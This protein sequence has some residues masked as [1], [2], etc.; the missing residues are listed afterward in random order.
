MKYQTIEEVAAKWGVT[1]RQV[2]DYCTKGRISGVTFDGKAWRIPSNATKPG[3]KPRSRPQSPSILSILREE[4]EARMPG[5]IYHRLQIDFTYSSNHMEGSRLTHE[6]T[7]WI[8]ETHTVGEIGADVPVDDIVETANH[9]RAIDSVITSARAALTERYIKNL[10]AILKGGTTDSRKPW[11]AVGN[12]KRLENSVGGIETAPPSRV[13]ADM[14]RLLAWYNA[15]GH[16]FEDILAFHVRFETIHPFQD[17]NGRIGRLILLKEC[18]KHGITPFI[19]DEPLR[20]F[21][22]RGLE[23]WRKDIRGYLLDTCRTGQDRFSAMLRHYGHT[24][25]ADAADKR[26]S[27]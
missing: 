22:Y 25:A 27:R 12:Y 18:L 20:R 24:A 10:H 23:G 21:Y 15:S 17:G 9:F 2:R 16:T 26:D 4:M 13:H 3:R 11:F 5:G 7:R 19:I 8:F 1:P 14:V 6:Q